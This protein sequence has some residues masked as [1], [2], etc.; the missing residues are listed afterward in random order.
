MLTLSD[1]E[2]NEDYELINCEIFEELFKK[3]EEGKISVE[4]LDEYL[5]QIYL[6]DDKQ[7]VAFEYFNFDENFI[8][9][10]SDH[11]FSNE[12]R[13]DYFT[14]S[15]GVEIRI[16]DEDEANDAIYDYLDE[17]VDESGVPEWLKRYVNVEELVDDTISMEGR[18]PSLSSYDGIE[19]ESRL[20][21]GYYVYRN[22]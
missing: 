15:N 11:K 2:K 19:W 5:K 18:G 16:M 8:Q 21:P 10:I 12:P 1:I 17:L 22:N 7:Y 14:A 9:E 3:A 6:W 13:T 20:F 4:Q